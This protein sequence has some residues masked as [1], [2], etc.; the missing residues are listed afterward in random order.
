M[1]INELKGSCF[2]LVVSCLTDSVVAIRQ[3]VPKGL[4]MIVSMVS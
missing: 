4:F 1:K 3:C 2:E